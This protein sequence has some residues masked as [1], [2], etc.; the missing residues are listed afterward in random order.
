[1][2]CFLCDSRFFTPPTLCNPCPAFRKLQLSG[3]DKSATRDFLA[4]SNSIQH[5]RMLIGRRVEGIRRGRPFAPSVTSL[6]S[7]SPLLLLCFPLI[8][9]GRVLA[10]HFLTFKCFVAVC[11]AIPSYDWP[12]GVPMF[13][14]VVPVVFRV[15]LY[16]I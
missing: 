15:L 7:P 12:L 10:R 3:S 4:R 16:T 9:V 1:M 2:A 6:P 14:L 5:Y 11:F 13:S 8:I